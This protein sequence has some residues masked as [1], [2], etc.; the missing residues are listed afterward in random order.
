[1]E[2]TAKT[3]I[4]RTGDYPKE[5]LPL[6]EDVLK[7]PTWF[8][9]H[10]HHYATLKN[11]LPLMSME[12]VD[13]YFRG[14]EEYHL[15]STC[16]NGEGWSWRQR[17]RGISPR[18]ALRGRS[19]LAH[20]GGSPSTKRPQNSTHFILHESSYRDTKKKHRDWLVIVYMDQN[21]RANRSALIISTGVVRYLNRFAIAFAR[22]TCTLRFEFSLLALTSSVNYMLLNFHVGVISQTSWSK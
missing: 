15:S 7:P 19:I 8:E 17:R 18:R 12:V 9:A 22:S 20:A 11:N 21:S 16:A 6:T 3:T 10:A 1:M 4:N 5:T 2:Q 14:F 13:M